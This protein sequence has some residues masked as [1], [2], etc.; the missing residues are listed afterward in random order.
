MTKLKKKS[1]VTKHKLR[2]NS[3]CDQTHKL[4]LLKKLKKNKCD[5]TK[6]N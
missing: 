2:E 6:P 5:K 4:K 1:I 3:K